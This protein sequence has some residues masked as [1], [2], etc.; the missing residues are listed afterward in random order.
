MLNINQIIL[1]YSRFKRCQ[2]NYNSVKQDSHDFYML[3]MLEID[4]YIEDYY[5]YARDKKQ[6]KDK[7]DKLFSE[8]PILKSYLSLEFAKNIYK[9][10]TKKYSVSPELNK[11]G[12]CVLCKYPECLI[13]VDLENNK[14]YCYQINDEKII[15]YIEYGLKNSEKYITDISAN[16][17]SLMQVIYSDLLVSDVISKMNIKQLRTFIQKEL[18]A[19]RMFDNSYILD[20]SNSLPVNITEEYKKLLELYQSDQISKDDY[21]KR[22]Y[23]YRIISGEKIENLFFQADIEDREYIMR[24]YEDLSSINLNNDKIHIR[25]T[26]KEIN[27]EVLKRRKKSDTK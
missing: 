3:H 17:I 13:I 4:K 22:V 14:N 24:A 23:Y 10:E 11:V 5:A 6:N 9:N 12:K 25:T 2:L 16:E 15:S 27:K 7:I 20:N 26:S 1:D 8:H 18:N 21:C 19:A